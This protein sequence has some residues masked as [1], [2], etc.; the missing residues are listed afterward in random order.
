MKLFIEL[1]VLF[2]YTYF[3]MIIFYNVDLKKNFFK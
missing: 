1:F 3:I 2:T